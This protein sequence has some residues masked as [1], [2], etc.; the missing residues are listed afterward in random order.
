MLVTDYS[1]KSCYLARSTFAL[2]FGEQA[3][4]RLYFIILLAPTHELHLLHNH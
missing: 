2:S 3:A 4:D 1:H